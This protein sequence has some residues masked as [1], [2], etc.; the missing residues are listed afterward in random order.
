LGVGLVVAAYAVRVVLWTLGWWSGGRH[1]RRHRRGRDDDAKEGDAAE[2][3][4]CEMH[5]E[6]KV[7]CR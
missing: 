7:K 4:G 2:D 5:L 3:D 1:D 6:V